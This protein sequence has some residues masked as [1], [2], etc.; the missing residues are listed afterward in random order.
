MKKIFGEYCTLVPRTLTKRLTLVP[1]TLTLLARTIY[2]RCEKDGKPIPEGI[3]Y[4]K[5]LSKE[6]EEFAEIRIVW[7]M[8]SKL[9]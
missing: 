4:W 9:D 5:K 7:D 8:D 2:K 6:P 1:R 3:E